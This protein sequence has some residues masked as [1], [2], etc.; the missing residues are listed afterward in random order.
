MQAPI[1]LKKN[2]MATVTANPISGHMRGTLGGVVF[3][4]LRGKTVVSNTPRRIKK[5][6]VT[7]KQ[8]RSKFRDASRWAKAQ[9]LDPQ[10][11][12][13]YAAKA[14]KLKLPNAYTAAISD[15]MRK[16]VIS[17]VNVSRYNGKADDVIS[18]KISKRD[19]DV[20][21]AE[22][23]LYDKEGV[24]LETG[25]ATR[26][27]HRRFF[28]RITETVYERKPVRICIVAGAPGMIRT[29]KEI[30]VSA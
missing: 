8:N 6:S 12:S 14:K 4:Q 22:I 29:M 21:H 16:S 3:R 26:K 27:D 24:Q 18:M 17:D 5:E 11:K 23:I 15:Y 13:F 1:L 9:L 7:Q 20:R 25:I 10:K 19:F 2:F 28:Y 30:T